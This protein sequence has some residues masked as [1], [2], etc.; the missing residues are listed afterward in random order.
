VGSGVE[1]V[2]TT[3]VATPVAAPLPLARD[4]CGNAPTGAVIS[5]RRVAVFRARRGIDIEHS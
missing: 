1:I 4:L 5:A 2:S 3:L